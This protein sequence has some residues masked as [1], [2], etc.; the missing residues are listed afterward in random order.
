MQNIILPAAAFERHN[1][2]FLKDKLRTG[3]MVLNGRK[4]LYSSQYFCTKDEHHYGN[5]IYKLNTKGRSKSVTR[6]HQ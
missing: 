2:K 5:K 3:K 4:H 1:L 6:K